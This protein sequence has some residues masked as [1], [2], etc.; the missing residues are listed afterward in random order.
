M[1]TFCIS[2]LKRG[3]NVCGFERNRVTMWNVTEFIDKIF[4]ELLAYL[5]Y[6][7]EPL[8]KDCTY[9]DFNLMVLVVAKLLKSTICATSIRFLS[10]DFNSANGY[11]P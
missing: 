8:Y 3:N 4:R 1:K 6:F 2:K 9:A 11:M 10:T 5:K 7:D